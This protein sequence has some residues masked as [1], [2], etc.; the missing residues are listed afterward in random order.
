MYRLPISPPSGSVVTQALVQQFEVVH[1]APLDSQQYI[2]NGIAVLGN[3]T[4]GDV[5][6]II[7]PFFHLDER[8]RLLRRSV[9]GVS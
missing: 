1:I 6:E 4:P 8:L 2:Q 9:I 7:F 5:S 3:A